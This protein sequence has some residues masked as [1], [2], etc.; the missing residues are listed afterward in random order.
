MQLSEEDIREFQEL[1]RKEFGE[2]ISPATARTQAVRLLTISKVLFFPDWILE[3]D[4]QET[5]SPRESAAYMND[6]TKHLRNLRS[7]I[8]GG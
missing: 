8:D 4:G 6:P 3:P 7:Q 1:W 5:N 2:E